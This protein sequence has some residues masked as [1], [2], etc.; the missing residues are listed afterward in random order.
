VQARGGI[1]YTPGLGRYTTDNEP[2]QK[3]DSTDTGCKGI[4]ETNM[5]DDCYSL[6]YARRKA[7]TEMTAIGRLR[8]EERKSNGTAEDS[9]VQVSDVSSSTVESESASETPRGSSDT[10]SASEN[11]KSVSASVSSRDALT[12]SSVNGPAA[13]DTTSVE[14]AAEKQHV[15]SASDV[16]GLAA[17]LT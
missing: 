12:S 10:D 6:N 4:S 15:G 5:E 2:T 9:V 1:S 17:C 16:D 11:E 13:D 14:V 7:I 3:D 8:L